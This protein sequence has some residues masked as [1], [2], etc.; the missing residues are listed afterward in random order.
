MLSSIFKYLEQVFFNQAE[1][2]FFCCIRCSINFLL[3]RLQLL[4]VYAYVQLVPP[5]QVMEVV[6]VLVFI[7]DLIYFIFWKTIVWRWRQHLFFSPLSSIK[8]W[9]TADVTSVKAATSWYMFLVLTCLY[10][11]NRLID[12]FT[13][14][15]WHYGVSSYSFPMRNIMAL[16]YDLSAHSQ[17]KPC[18]IGFG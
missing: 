9:W 13:L 5:Q 18:L 7:M 11:S 14:S 3:I 2:L 15:F 10:Y 16:Q 12:Y 1:L 4:N 8:R 6:Y 17:W